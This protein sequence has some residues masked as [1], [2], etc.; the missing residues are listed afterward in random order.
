MLFKDSTARTIRLQKRMAIVVAALLAGAWLFGIRP[1]RAT[2]VDVANDRT[3]VDR[4][5]TVANERAGKLPQLKRQVEELREQVGR[6]KSMLPRS[7]LQPALADLVRLAGAQS[8]RKFTYTQDS[9]KA[10]PLCIEQPVTIKFE[11][12]FTDAYEF[13]EAIDQMQRLTRVR[14]INIKQL[15]TRGNGDVRVEMSLSFFFSEQ[16]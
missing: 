7:D 3:T 12:S 10:L 5:L 14:D 9:E 13:L 15:D 1:L 16:W 11:S 4:D 6:F 2:V 8:L